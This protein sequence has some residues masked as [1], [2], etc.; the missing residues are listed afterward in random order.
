MKS[1]G[2]RKKTVMR[3]RLKCLANGLKSSE[4]KWMKTNSYNVKK[5]IIKFENLKK[6]LSNLCLN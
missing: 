1:D 2:I 3:I 6:E 5:R 4:W